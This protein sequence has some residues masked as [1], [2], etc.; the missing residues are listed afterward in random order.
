MSNGKSSSLP[1]SMSNIKTNLLSG[2]KRLKFC[3][4]PTR[5]KPGPMLF[6]VVATAVKFVI[7]SLTF[8]DKI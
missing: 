5:F 7:R 1:A 8:S 4:G 2:E 6:M 3:V